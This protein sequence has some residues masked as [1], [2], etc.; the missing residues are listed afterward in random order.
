MPDDNGMI[1]FGYR[2]GNLEEAVT[3]EAKM[4]KMMN[5][6]RVEIVGLRENLKS[7]AVVMALKTEHS[8]RYRKRRLK[9]RIY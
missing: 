2:L 9:R 1:D 3:D 7:I 4:A 8:F 5:E 6:L